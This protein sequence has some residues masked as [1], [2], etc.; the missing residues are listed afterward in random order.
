MKTLSL[1]F[2]LLLTPTFY[3]IA[4]EHYTIKGETLILNTEVEGDLDLLTLKLDKGYR[5]F[6]R[7]SYNN[8]HELINTRD[9][10][11]TYFN[12]FRHTLTELTKESNMST[13]Q[14]AFSKYGLKQFIKAYNKKGTRRYAYTEDK[15]ETQ[16]RLG[17]FGGI[18]N[19][20]LVEN[21]NN[22][23]TVYFGTEVE[24]FEKKEHPRQSG[25]IGLEQTLKSDGFNYTSTIINLGYRFRFINC[26][27]FNSYINL[28]LATY[29]FSKHVILVENENMTLEEMTVKNNTFRV[30]FIFGIG[31]DIKVSENGF[32]TLIYNEIVSIFVK[33]NG[34]FPIN[35]SIGYK[36]NL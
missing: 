23:K 34:H 2:I 16:I 25:F 22:T 18:T 24:L 11:S 26:S 19:H 10:D 32:I 15:V 1:L 8:I 7:D 28:Q 13:E 30:P 9:I 14:V 35:F 5:F 17:V 21:T 3:S 36:F 27:V 29:T 31:S 33:N 4:Q 20:P 6:V 12:E